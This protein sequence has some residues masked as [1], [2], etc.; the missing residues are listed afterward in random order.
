MD[1]YKI[2]LFQKCLI[3]IIYAI[4]N[5][6]PYIFWRSI[7][8]NLLF[9]LNSNYGD[10]RITQYFAKRYYD[11]EIGKY[12][13]DIEHLFKEK[14]RLE[15]VGSFCSIAPGVTFAGVNHPLTRITTHPST[16]RSRFN[17]IYVDKTDVQISPDKNKKVIIGNDVWIG[18]K[19]M[20]LP[21]VKIGD[22]AV[23]AAGSV[24]TKNVE[25]YSI[26]GGVPAKLIRYRFNEDTIK[27]LLKSKW[28][29]M[30]DK[31]IKELYHKLGYNSVNNID[32]VNEEKIQQILSNFEEK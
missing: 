18:T 32:D 5:L 8:T 30:E 14:L 3:S 28:W 4:H 31:D 23:V 6:R 12:T 25:P 13:Y 15:S 11:I 16:Y 27:I 26:V 22:G 7:S 20:I 17:F 24:V 29:S 1:E 9:I 2:S 21:S 10:G 19:S